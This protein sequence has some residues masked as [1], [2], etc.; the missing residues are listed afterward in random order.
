MSEEE[1]AL[2]RFLI[3]R[4]R[5]AK[6]T[7]TPKTEDA[8][9]HALTVALRRVRAALEMCFADPDLEANVRRD[10]LVMYSGLDRWMDGFRHAR[11]DAEAAW[12]SAAEGLIQR[13]ELAYSM[14]ETHR[15]NSARRALEMT[16][17]TSST[18]VE[19]AGR[20]RSSPDFEDVKTEVFSRDEPSSPAPSSPTTER[21]G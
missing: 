21:Y 1:A 7:P 18:K 11:S 12:L 19:V 17:G 16:A 14:A 2:A 4:F 3:T 8:L 15:P 13:L 6:A 20:V 10:L 5:E 9:A